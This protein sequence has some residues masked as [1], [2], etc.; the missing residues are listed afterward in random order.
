MAKRGEAASMRRAATANEPTLRVPSPP[1]RDAQRVIERFEKAKGRRDTFASTIDACYEFALPLR[2]R[3]YM[4]DG[5]PDVDR[6]FDSTAVTAIQGL[7]SQ[8]LDDVWPADQTPFELKAGP[9]IEEEKQEEVNRRLADISTAV[10]EAINNSNFRSGAHEALLD[11]CIGTGILL[12]EAGDAVTPVSFRA[13]PLTQCVLDTGPRN[14]VDALFMP[15]KVQLQHIEELWPL[16]KL[17]Q[18]LADRRE[19]EPTLEIELL[20]G[21]ERD[22][23]ARGREVWVQRVA[24]KERTAGGL[25]LEERSE[26]VG[27]CPFVAPSFSRVAGEAMGRGPV[28]MA[29]PDIRVANKLVELMLETADLQL[30]GIW[31]YDDD[32]VINPDTAILEPGALIPRMPGGKGLENLAPTGNV[33]LA[34]MQ[35]D[36]LRAAIKEALYVNDLGD[37]TKT[38]KTAT[39]IAQRTA[40]RA[41]RLTGAYG[42]L[43]KEFLFPLVGRVWWLLKRSQGMADLPPIDGDKIKVRPLSPLTRAQAQDDILRHVNFLQ[44]VAS[45]LGP[46]AP[47]LVADTDKLTRFL[48][49]KMGF[50]PTLLRTQTEQQALMQQAMTMAQQQGMIPGAGGGA[51]A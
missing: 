46:Q 2:Q 29:L 4:A 43:L 10:I 9:G 34:Q 11:Y 50:N 20:E 45:I 3:S 8:T 38:P 6:L 26:G 44:T 28:M 49:D 35:L 1:Q 17:P 25:L 47:L 32:G 12:I 22:W 7:A 5:G 39:E 40:D 42:R 19:R 27:S 23:S 14:E 48:A 36:Q 24:W 18:E 33:N 21:V 15:R 13:V 16:A 30:S 37:I 31:M 51:P 41:R